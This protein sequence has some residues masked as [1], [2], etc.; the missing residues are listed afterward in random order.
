MRKTYRIS[1]IICI[2]SFFFIHSGFSQTYEEL[3]DKSYDYLEKNDLLSAEESLRSAMRLEPANPTNYA[4]LTNL[5]TIQRRQGKKEEA[6][7]SYT[8]ALSRRPQD[9][10][11]LE[12]RATLYSELGEPEK[13]LTDYNT[14]LIIEP[15]HQES[16][17]NR[18]LIHLQLKNFLLAEADFDK[19]L[20][21]NEK[22]VR[23]RMGHAILE[24]MRGN[25]DE[26]ERIYTYLIS[27]M[28]R[29]WILYEGRA[30]VYFMMGKNARA[31]AD[32]NRLFVETEPSASL[33]VL[34]GK[35]KLAQY[36]K[37]AALR[38]L[39]KAREMGY[40]PLVID[41]LVRMAK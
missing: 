38:D 19:L 39:E 20:E 31:M 18:G 13:A 29:E 6:L 2:A 32:L 5:G 10:T 41:E 37:E 40:D 23:G 17:Y 28:P 25:Y 1:L 36:E 33:Y 27:Q 34:R 35:V 21:L 30:D 4:L 9:I 12:N 26:S 15:D 22:T 11:I 24:K 3:I 16:L 7:L 14:L 8:A